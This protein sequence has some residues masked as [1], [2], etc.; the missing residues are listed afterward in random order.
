MITIQLTNVSS[1]PLG[2]RVLVDLSSLEGWKFSLTIVCNVV[3]DNGQLLKSVPRKS[4]QLQSE[5]QYYMRFVC[6]LFEKK[7]LWTCMLFQELLNHVGTRFQLSQTICWRQRSWQSFSFCYCLVKI[8]F[9]LILKNSFKKILLLQVLPLGKLVLA[10]HKEN[11]FHA[12]WNNG[13]I[14]IFPLI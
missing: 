13:Y 6:L 2:I 7:Y 11:Y 9:L 5:V 4:Y 14:N 12:I 1:L 10:Y 3:T 8:I